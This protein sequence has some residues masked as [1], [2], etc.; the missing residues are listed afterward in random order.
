MHVMWQGQTTTTVNGQMSSAI[1]H[2]ID[3][4]HD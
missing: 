2:V 1:T 3:R 4:L